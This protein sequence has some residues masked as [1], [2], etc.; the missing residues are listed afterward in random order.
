M[1]R[2]AIALVLGILL[3]VMGMPDA[4]PQT[5]P[6]KEKARISGRVTD[7]AGRPVQGA[8]VELKNSRFDNV[9]SAAPDQGI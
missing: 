5:T 2:T 8:T 1:K 4:S 3:L 6:A 7:F 9:A